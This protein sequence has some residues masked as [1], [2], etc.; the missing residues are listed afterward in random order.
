MG[1][2]L[3]AVL[4]TVVTLI[5]VTKLN[6]E[7]TLRLIRPEGSAIERLIAR[8]VKG[9]A[10]FGA[11]VGAV[12]SGDVLVYV[13]FA[14]CDGGIPACL[15][16]AAGG[17]GHRRLMIRLDRFGRSEDQ[18]IALLAHELHHATEVASEPGVTDVVSFQKLF[19]ARGWKGPLGFETTAAL[20][21]GKRVEAE[22]R[23]RN[24]TR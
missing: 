4:L 16:W 3:S 22:L 13:Q 19:E 12:E 5:N 14:R 7:Q 23:Q 2:R 17:T 21:T 10:T 15:L 20:D 24:G 9:S 6:A 18:L 8:G 1:Q 11:T